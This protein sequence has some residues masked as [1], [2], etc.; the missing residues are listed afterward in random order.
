MA[1]EPDDEHALLRRYADYFRKA[2]EADGMAERAHDATAR[3]SFR[4]TAEGW[5]RLASQVKKALRRKSL[6][7]RS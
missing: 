5:R 1:E 6:Q 4:L 2:E 7:G 3:R